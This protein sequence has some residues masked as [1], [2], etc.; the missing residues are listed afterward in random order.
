[1]SAIAGIV[2]FAGEPVS[3]HDLAASSRRMMEPELLEAKFWS[4]KS[5]G[6]VVR[7]SLVTSED[8]MERQPW[9]SGDGKR[10]LVLDGRID[11]REQLAAALGIVL[12]KETVPDGWLLLQALERWGEAAPARLIGD[13]VFALWDAQ[14]RRLLLARDQMGMRTLYYY[15]GRGFL[16]FASTYP[17]LL[18][19]PGVPNEVDELGIADFLVLNPHYPE[20]TFYRN[21]H[22]LPPATTAIFDHGGLSFT[23]YWTAGSAP[24]LRLSCDEEYVEAAR[25]QLE[26][27]VACRMRA[28]DAI[29]SQI[30]GG[31][32]S[33][34]VATTAA[35][36]LVPNRMFAVCSVPPEGMTLPPPT[37]AWY[38]DERPYLR[39]IAALHPNL[40]IHLA[41]SIEPHWIEKDPSVFFEAGGMPA[42]NVTNIG[43]FMPG[44]DLVTQ[45]GIKVLLSGQGGNPAWSYDGLRALSDLFKQ[46]NWLHLGRE[47]Y[48]T[49]KRAPYGWDWKRLLSR[50][51]LRPRLPSA[52]LRLR[53]R[54]KTGEAELWSAYSMINP[55]FAR[56]IDLDERNRKAGHDMCFPGQQDSRTMMLAMLHKMEHGRDI[57]TAI[58]TLT[59]I[60]NRAPLCDIRLIDFFLSLPQQQ[61]LQNG[62]SRRLARQALSDRLPAS[63]L[64]KE[65]IGMQNPE[66][67]YRMDA[68]R[69]EMSA[70]LAELAKIPLV[71]R[72]IDLPRLEKTVR[73]WPTKGMEVT[74]ALPRALNVARFLRWTKNRE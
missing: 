33:S 27:A 4:E 7:Q 8:M 56:E 49:G 67:S 15:Q 14:K 3:A 28:K 51:V 66:I 41:S 12:N 20:N 25:E 35:R 68:L 16:A 58:R 53:R 13:F 31:L 24:Q 63:V 5:A 45:A 19:L 2:R 55:A 57:N 46:G 11:N 73:D 29:A 10:V 36:Q 1:M 6:L 42:R 30:S 72:C 9:M 61:F 37:A 48:L 34:A 39:E 40:D 74:L 44:Y 17:A 71:A 21:V 50:E 64:E 32:D 22:R 60:E 65:R 52:L 69:S 62:V 18:D 38:N 54:I 23:T 70:E 59:G 26:R 47:L 43:W